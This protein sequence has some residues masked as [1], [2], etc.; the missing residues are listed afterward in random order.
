MKKKIVFLFLACALVAC[1]EVEQKAGMKLAAAREAFRQGNY[2]EAKLQIDS[3]K[4][5]YPQAFDARRAGIALM[6]QVEVAEQEQTLL[7]LDSLLQVKQ[8]DLASVRSRYVFEKDTVYQ[9]IGNYF[10]PSQVVEKN[11][12]RSYLRFQTD[13]QGVMTMTSIYCG[14]RSIHHTGVKVVVPDGSFAQTPPSRDSYETTH[15]GET[16]EKA[17]YRQGFDGHVMGFLCLNSEQ[18][19]RVEY[20]GDRPFVTTMSADDRRAVTEIYRLSQL[21]TAITKIHK[22]KEEAATK[23]SFVKQKMQE[24]ELK[25]QSAR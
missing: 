23:L 12:H 16:I 8:T 1:N 3:I 20:Q 22:E 24:R 2:S 10:Y 7:Y 13:E 14:S 5:L 21:L 18:N 9:S 19:I 17:D 15:L 25:Q 11:L 4:L 6:Q